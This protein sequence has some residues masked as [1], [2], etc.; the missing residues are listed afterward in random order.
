MS[1]PLRLVS[2]DDSDKPGL[3]MTNTQINLA[4]TQSQGTQSDSSEDD[5]IKPTSPQPAIVSKV[6]CLRSR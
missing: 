6:P 5:D 3:V 1:Q 2:Q 4:N